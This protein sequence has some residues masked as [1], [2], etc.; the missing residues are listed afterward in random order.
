MTTPTFTCLDTGTHL[1]TNQDGD[2]LGNGGWTITPPR[3]SQ[4]LFLC[5][6]FSEKGI[7]SYLNISFIYTSCPNGKCRTDWV[8]I[9]V[10]KRSV[11]EV[12]SIILKHLQHLM[13][14]HTS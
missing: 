11:T 6:L 3:T 10:P 5:A 1:W 8:I 14:R 13:S 9:T 12:L 4:R 2:T 7:I